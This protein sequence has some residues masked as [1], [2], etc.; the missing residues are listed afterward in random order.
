LQLCS[1]HYQEIESMTRTISRQD[2]QARIER[3]EPIIILEAL[4]E[5]YYLKGHLPGALNLPHDRVR[6]LAPELVPDRNA[7]IM[8]YCASASSRN[9]HVAA[10]IL[11][12]MGYTDV[13]VYAEGKQDWIEA[14]LPIETRQNQ[15]A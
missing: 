6:E 10:E 2:L 11:R 14:G 13:S 4:P 7:A 3:K 15:A 9:S 12:G 8:T 5:S 1:N